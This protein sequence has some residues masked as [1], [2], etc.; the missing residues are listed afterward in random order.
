MQGRES[1]PAVDVGRE[2]DGLGEESEAFE[3]EWH[4][5]DAAG[6]VMNA[7]QRSP[8]SKERTVPETAPTAKSK[9]TT[10]VH[11]RASWR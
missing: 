10:G 5:D 9:P 4:T 7:G 8:S 3:G 11:A 1:V 2:E 6:V